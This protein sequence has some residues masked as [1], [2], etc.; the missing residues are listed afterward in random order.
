MNPPDK[1]RIFQFKKPGENNIFFEIQRT[2][3]L[4]PFA[5]FVTTALF[6]SG[7][8]R[9]PKFY[10]TWR[11]C[12]ASLFSFRRRVG[13][14]SQ[15]TRKVSMINVICKVVW[16]L[17]ESR[18]HE[19]GYKCLACFRQGAI[20]HDGFR[21]GVERVSRKIEDHCKSQLTFEHN[22]DTLFTFLRYIY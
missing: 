6:Y 20:D 21:I 17:S 19:G 8:K 12:H 18:G 4:L 10:D 15:R 5:R 9:I 22:W 11:T 1:D 13:K 3:G 16:Y 7:K 14:C 2:S